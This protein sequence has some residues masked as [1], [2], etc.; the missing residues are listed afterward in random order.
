MIYKSLL[1]IFL[2]SLGSLSVLAS[3][4]IAQERPECY[5]IDSSGQLT[6]LTDLCN[7]SQKRSP[8][9]EAA[10]NEGLNIINNNNNNVGGGEASGTRPG[11]TSSSSVVVGDNLALE[12]SS[13][14]SSSFID[15]EIGVD[16]TAY[17]RRFKVAPVATVRNDLREEAFQFDTDRDSLTSILRQSRGRL[18]FLIYRYPKF[19]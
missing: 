12:L 4:T 11:T 8:D 19:K 16:Y 18:P 2:T 6:D 7:V 10:T 14:D 5:I 13:G 17:I 3:T 15:N 1:T 9:P